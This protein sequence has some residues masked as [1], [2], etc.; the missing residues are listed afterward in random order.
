MNELPVSGMTSA[1]TLPPPP[2][3]D[4]ASAISAAIRAVWRVLI[5][6]FWIFSG[7]VAV[8]FIAAAAAIM[9]MTPQYVAEAVL[10][11]NPGSNPITDAQGDNRFNQPDRAKIQSE[12]DVIHSRDIAKKVARQ[13]AMINDREFDY[14]VGLDVNQTGGEDARYDAIATALLDN[15]EVAL[16]PDSY[17][18]TIDFTS[19]DAVKAA[20]IANAFADIYLR[21]N[22]GARSGSAAEQAAYL[23]N[24]RSEKATEVQAAESALAQ[25]KASHGIVAGETTGTVTDQQIG[26]LASALATA[27]SE[28]AAAR[29]KVNSARQQIAAGNMDAVANVLGSPVVTALRTQRG[30]LMQN[31]D[32]IINRYGPLHPDTIRVTNQL[33]SLDGEIKLEATRLINALESDAAAAE[34]RAAS[35]RGSLNDL[36]G[37]QAQNAKASVVADQL[38]RDITAKRA[39]FDTLAKAEEAAE[40][41]TN[42]LSNV[43]IVQSARPP[44]EPTKPKRKFLLSGAL[45][46]ALMAGA[47]IIT[48]LELLSRGI[49]T[50]DDVERRLGVRL[51]TSIPKLPKSVMAQMSPGDFTIDRPMTSYAESLRS[52]RAA[53]MAQSHRGDKLPPVIA[54]TS[55]VPAEGKTSLTLSLARIMA[56]AGDKVVVLDGDF[57]RAGLSGM[58]GY[59]SDVTLHDVLKD[60]ADP[61]AAIKADKVDGVSIIANNGPLFTPVDLLSGPAMGNLL[62]RLSHDYDAV[63]IDTPPFLG[64]ADART[65]VNQAAAVIMIAAWDK[66]PIDAVEK[67]LAQ[68]QVDGAPLVGAAITM[69]DANAEMMGLT[70]YSKQYASY[71]ETYD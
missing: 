39:A 46:F 71:Y 9:M 38:T 18:I 12:V 21:S 3:A 34:A 52:L 30:Q 13:L 33:K 1:V 31:R 27:Q 60:G 65:L 5:E 19:Q 2:P 43:Q 40:V 47:G 24:R 69:V 11:V 48:T 25:Y 49:R 53:L 17:T 67:T 32:D 44:E 66:T 63:I 61:A 29:A 59:K 8:I 16:N 50:A 42:S 23:A 6:R 57:R 36:R 4:T 51:L 26:P 45:V 55:S 41:G 20:R 56:L 35:L 15:L 10:K 14:S 58:S 7:V 22:V 54:L 70:Y 64:V 68:L 28:A 37:A 62:R